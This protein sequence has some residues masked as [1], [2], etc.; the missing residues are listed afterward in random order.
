[1]KTLA[2]KT[3]A[4][5]AAAW[6]VLA[7]AAAMAQM[8]MPKPG[9][10]VKKLDML[11]GSWTLDGEMKASEMSPAGKVMET[12][13]CEWMEGGFFL[14]CHLDFKTTMGNGS[15]MSIMGYSTD[16]KSYT[17]RE[18]NSWGEF[19]DSKGSLDGDTWT[20]INQQKEGNMKMGRFTMKVTS[21]ASYNFSYEASPDGTKW[22]MVMDG[23]ATKGK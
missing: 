17:Y 1:M 21:P 12:E 18:F 5:I 13:K 15:G 23:K 19:T 11:V 2:M 22:T 8:E 16:D 14:V 10:E 7:A 6:L 4:M 9:P 20:W 3:L